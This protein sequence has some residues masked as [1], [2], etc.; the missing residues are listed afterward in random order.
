MSTLTNSQNN[1]DLLQ[2]IMQNLKK[3]TVSEL[4]DLYFEVENEI[5]RKHLSSN[6]Q[7]Q[8]EN[9]KI[10]GQLVKRCYICKN[11]L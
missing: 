2:C 3:F 10:K 1:T 6:G 8:W 7:C 4:E 9:I 5:D 11:L